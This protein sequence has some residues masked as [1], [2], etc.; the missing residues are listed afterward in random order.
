MRSEGQEVSQRLPSRSKNIP[1][2]N[3]IWGIRERNTG[4]V[5]LK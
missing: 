3:D 5:I 1:R 4:E 2:D